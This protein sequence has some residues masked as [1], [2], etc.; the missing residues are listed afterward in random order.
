MT[1]PRAGARPT[2][3]FIHG[4]GRTGRCFKGMEKTVAKAGFDTWRVSYPSMKGTMRE[5]AEFVWHRMQAELPDG[6]RIAITHSAGG[7]I[8]R[9]LQ[10]RVGWERALMLAPPNQGSR[11]ARALHSRSAKLLELVCGPKGPELAHPDWP[12]PKLQMSV[13]AGTAP[14]VVD[15]PQATLGRTLGAFG[16]AC[17][18]DGTLHVDDTRHEQMQEFAVVP[19]GHTF[20]MDHPDVRAMALRFLTHGRLR[21]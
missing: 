18:T 5:S 16:P 2:I 13:I 20:L 3:V 12:E 6:P 17:E 11:L 10:D 1:D 21:P 9:L 7:I 4:L 14:H 15:T 8:A 19:A